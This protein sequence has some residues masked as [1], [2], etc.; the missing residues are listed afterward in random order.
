MIISSCA[1]IVFAIPA[2]QTYHLLSKVN[3][4]TKDKAEAPPKKKEFSKYF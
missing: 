4:E 2:F 1:I 3:K